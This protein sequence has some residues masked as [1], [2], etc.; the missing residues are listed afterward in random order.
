MERSAGGDAPEN[1][2]SRNTQDHRD[3]VVRLIARHQREIYLYALGRVHAQEA[4]EEILQETNVVLC[5]KCEEY[6]L[7]TNFL[8]WA[9][10]VA[11]FE[12]RKYLQRKKRNAPVF[13]DIFESGLNMELL[14]EVENV[15]HTRELLRECIAALTSEDQSLLKERYTAGAT[16]K[17]VAAASGRSIDSIYRAMRRI[18]AALFRCIQRKRAQEG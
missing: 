11:E 3:E 14:A 8:G 1:T 4:A 15:D 6:R 7:G 2:E 5:R 12:T 10:T 18:H 13:S 17:S 9:C 16:T